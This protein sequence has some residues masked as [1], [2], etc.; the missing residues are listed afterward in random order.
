MDDR[1]GDTMSEVRLIPVH[2]YNC[3]KKLADVAM[4]PGTQRLGCKDCSS[5]TRI[6]IDDDLNITV[7]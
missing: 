1:G 7:D 5:K 2:C 3:S 6:F 4:V